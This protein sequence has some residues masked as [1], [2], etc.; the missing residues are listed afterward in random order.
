MHINIFTVNFVIS[1]PDF[2]TNNLLLKFYRKEWKFVELRNFPRRNK[3]RSCRNVYLGIEYP[4]IDS[5]V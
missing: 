2:I 3:F 4:R 5:L 1:T